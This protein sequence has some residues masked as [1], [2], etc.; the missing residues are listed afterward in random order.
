MKLR[1]YNKHEVVTFRSTKATFGGLSN[2]ASGYTIFVNGI[3][4]PTSEALYQACRFPLYPEIQHEIISQHSPMTAKMISRKNDQYTRP[5]W[6]KVKIKIMRW[7]LEV[8]LSQ[9]WHTFSTVLKDTGAQ[10]IVEYTKLDKIW[11]ATDVEGSTL[12]GVNAL[13]RL[14]MELRE[15]YVKTNKHFKCVRP[16]DIPDFLLYENEIDWVCD[17]ANDIFDLDDAFNKTHEHIFA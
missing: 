12:E 10:P 5:D 15:N 6:E 2:M 1:K 11:G 14:L 4:I 7:A 9:N 8:K 17:E 16:L 13:G 3:F